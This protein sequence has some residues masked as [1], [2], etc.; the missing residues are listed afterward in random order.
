MASTLYAQ[1]NK[2]I[3]KRTSSNKSQIEAAQFVKDFLPIWDSQERLTIELA[4]AMPSKYYKFKPTPEMKTFAEQ[5]GHIA[6]TI[7]WMYEHVVLQ[8]KSGKTKSLD[9]TKMSKKEIIAYLRQAFERGRKNIK[10]LSKSELEEFVSFF[11]TGGKLKKKF[12]VLSVFDH[13]TN[14]RAKANLYMRLC[15]L[16]PPGYG[17]LRLPKE[18]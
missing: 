4:E 11:T 16:V 1:N 18:K 2:P 15:G 12:G 9:V 17:Y 8:K 7:D 10:S 6:H 14:H 3:P 5:M 13:I